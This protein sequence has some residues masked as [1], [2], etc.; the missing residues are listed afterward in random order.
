M[1]L[2]FL[3]VFA[4][5]CGRACALAVCVAATACHSK[6]TG[7]AD[8]SAG[9]PPV[10][11]VYNTATGR[12]EQLTADR[13]GD[14]KID[15]RAYM[16]GVHLK[17]IEIDRNGDGRPDRW[18]YYAPAASPGDGRGNAFDRSSVLVRAEEANGPDATITRREFYDRGVI[19][20]V[21]EDT[22]GDGRVD[23]WEQYDHGALV[24]IDMDL[25]GR[26]APDRRLVYRRD[27]TLDHLEG[28]P[29]GDGKFE[30]LKADG[31]PI[32]PA[33]GRRGRQG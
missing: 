9:V 6:P 15:T 25:Q 4:G 23:K 5:S 7:A 12:L 18:E 26:G 24:R 22:D 27:G 2:T 21:E 28:D 29:D 13:N 8:A 17:Y 11:P 19:Q 1:H 33:T 10:S 31:S 16:D 14:G 3:H 20:R 32:A 30:P